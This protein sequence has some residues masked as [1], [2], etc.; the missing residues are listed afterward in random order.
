M[1][2]WLSQLWHVHGAVLSS[3][4]PARIQQ[5]SLSLFNNTAIPLVFSCSTTVS[6]WIES[7]TGEHIRW[8]VIA[9]I[10]LYVGSYAMI[11]PSSNQFFQEFNVERNSLLDQVAQISEACLGFCQQCGALDDLFICALFEHYNITKCTQGEASYATYCQGA[12]LNSALVTMGLHQEIKASYRVPFFLME[13]RKR[14][15]ALVYMAEISIATFLGRPPRLS[16]RY[17]N[18]DP[19]LDLT[20]SQL[21]TEDPQELESAIAALDEQGY[22]LDGEIRETTWI[23]S[24]IKFVIMREQILEL[25]LGNHTRDEVRQ[26]AELIEQESEE[27]WANLPPVMSSLRSNPLTLEKKTVYGSH[28]RNV[29][30]QGPQAN[31][32][33]LHLVLMRKAGTGPAG[34]V[35]AA[36][37]ILSD[38]MQVYKYVE[39]AA[40]TSFIYALAVHGMRSA[41]ILAME[42]LRQERESVHSADLLLP[43]SRTIQDLAIFAAKLGDLEPG[44]GDQNLC[45]KGRK[46]ISQVLDTILSPPTTTGRPVQQSPSQAEQPG[47]IPFA[48]DPF[49]TQNWPEGLIMMDHFEYDM[50]APIAGPDQA[51]RL[52]LESI[53][54]QDWGV[55]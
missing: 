43:R 51:F 53:D 6:Q 34:L 48:F 37:M 27:H 28:F 17:I 11:T 32:L 24:S 35:K 5:L 33:L 31:S 29:F 13:L 23:R 47:V 20:D 36:Q 25:S 55:Q 26:K 18:L 38:V 42:L 45:E 19:P 52:W 4:D 22:S 3:Q 1:R 15:R 44:F 39:M 9:M 21:F 16:Y 54:C 40:A 10:A 8:G 50:S 14:L 12:E 2:R 41:V 7:A 46:V 30:C 49:Q